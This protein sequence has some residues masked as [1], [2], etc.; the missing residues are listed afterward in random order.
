VTTL[1]AGV[2]TDVGRI[3]TNNEDT[4][5][6]DEDLFAVA[7]G[8][9]GH[10]AGEVASN[11]AIAALRANFV[12][13]TLKGLV[14][15]VERANQRIFEQATDDPDLRGMGTTL[16]AVAIV[17]SEP[18]PGASEAADGAGA[19]GADDED[20]QADAPAGAGGSTP[21]TSI[22]ELGWVNVGDS[23]VYLLR[24]GEL[25][26]LSEDHS[27]V[28]EM[29]RDG[30][31]SPDE[32][33]THPR[34]HIVTRALGI[35]PSVRV[36]AET[37]VPYHGD[38]LLLCS[39]GL[40]EEVD[41]ARIAAT[42]RRLADPTDAAREL[43]RLAVEA[44]GRD[45]VTVVVVD[46]VDDGG[47]IEAATDAVA[48][49]RNSTDPVP[50]VAPVAPEVAAAAPA[51]APVQDEPEPKP[52]PKASRKRR[53][54]WRAA[55]FVLAFLAVLGAAAG[56]LGLFARHTYFVAF[57]GDQVVVYRGRPG[58]FLWFDPTLEQVTDVARPDVPASRVDEL[59]N[60][61]QEGT[62]G[63]ALTYV[64]NLESQITAQSSSTTTT[65]S[66]TTT[67]T[68]ATPTST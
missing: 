51:P 42:L 17:D 58:G 66:T 50:T 68:T 3:R 56:A 11:V 65:A 8:M 19:D 20:Q 67:G 48:R 37:V 31:L 62:L 57:R 2:A 53:A 38:R 30:Q 10:R 24:D 28:E 60:G 59:T 61:V 40:Y 46:V 15:A 13:R 54:T 26:Q 12:D 34:R 32:A 7:D 23:R 6:I 33:A 4:P 21:D 18:A 5:L 55:V 44:G 25:T 45:N 9:G 35:D 29:V 41:D 16:V 64:R 52:K 43:V 39:D 1:R 22:E 63:A 14:S 49:D 27:L 36:D 47:R